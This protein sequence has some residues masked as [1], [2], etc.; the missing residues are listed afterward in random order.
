MVRGRFRKITLM[1]I[2][3]MLRSGEIPQVANEMISVAQVKGKI[4]LTKIVCYSWFVCFVS[5]THIVI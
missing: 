4:N 1:A 5:N 2:L 3:R